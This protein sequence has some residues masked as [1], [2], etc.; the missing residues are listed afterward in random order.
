MVVMED[1]FERRKGMNCEGR[2]D[3]ILVVGP[4]EVPIP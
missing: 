4:I 2:M 1:D 3:L